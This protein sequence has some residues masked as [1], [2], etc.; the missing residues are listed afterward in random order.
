MCELLEKNMPV[1]LFQYNKRQYRVQYRSQL[2]CQGLIEGHTRLY[3][4]GLE[5]RLISQK[6]R[7]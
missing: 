1:H 7:H 3:T 6:K 4:T 2:S 5:W